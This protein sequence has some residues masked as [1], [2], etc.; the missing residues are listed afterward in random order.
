M[1]NRE[2]DAAGIPDALMRQSYLACKELNRSYG[3][4]YY[5][6]TLLLPPGKRPYVHALYGLARYA[7][8]IVDDMELDA[9]PAQRAELLAAFSD[10]F[11]ADVAIGSSDDR[12]IRA[13]VDTIRRWDIP[14]EHFRAFFRSMEMDLTVSRYQT[15]EDLYTYVYGSAAVIGLQMVPILEPTDPAAYDKACQ[16]GVAFQLANFIRDV[17]EDYARG[18][19][20]LPMSELEAFG[21]GEAELAG[22][23][24]DDRMRAALDFQIRRVEDLQ[25]NA[26]AGIGMLHP[27]S[28]DCIDAARILYCGIA[29]QVRTID[30]QV[31]TTR[32]TVSTARRLSV[33]LPAWRRA[34]A[35]RR[36]YGPGNVH[37]I[38]DASAEGR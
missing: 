19:V 28:R 13:V 6:A 23:R 27:S 22:H 31:F 1:S 29:E 8:E 12:I 32:A 34:R 3:K 16:L 11:F 35:A 18:R 5:L 17:G 24:V 10:R 36:R 26:E 2:L 14:V 9:S 33:A 38:T 25:R 4:T 20:Y 7:D 15:Y 30:Y 37:G 21:V